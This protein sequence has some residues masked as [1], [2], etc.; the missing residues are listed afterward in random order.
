M[1]DNF[2][3]DEE[4][5]KIQER[6]VSQAVALSHQ[7][8]KALTDVKLEDIKFKLDTQKS[9]Q[10][11]AEDVAGALSIAGALRSEETSNELIKNKSEELVNK[12]KAKA[13]EA[14]KKAIEAE[15]D[16]QKAERA[17]YEAVLNTF[18][19]YKHLPRWLMKVMVFILSPL[20]TIIGLVI[21]IP[22]GFV[23]ILIDNLDGIICRY[24][25]T[26]NGTK[27]KLKTI[28]WVLLGLL[29]VGIICLTVLKCLNKI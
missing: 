18:G 1:E 2:N 23:K 9:L 19:I 12:S 20:Y 29:V 27:P 26:S 11:Q 3:E 10:E 5:K 13:S 8:E 21:G 28:F 15:T 17:L 22:C 14:Q 4:L 24:E 25:D 16:V 6:K 7:N